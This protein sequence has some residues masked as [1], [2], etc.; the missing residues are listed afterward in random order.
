MQRTARLVR[1][2]VVALLI[3]GGAAQA[4][5]VAYTWTGYGGYGPTSTG[6]KCSTY[7]MTVDVTVDGDDVKG[8]FQQVWRE[9]RKFE[10]KLAPDGTFKLATT[11]GTGQP[12]EIRGIINEGKTHVTLDGYCK[13]EAAL[14]KK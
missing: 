12:M 11:T 8:V 13:F 2:G 4:E 3:T 7:K 14:A 5:P 10:A 6:N 1:V 9:V